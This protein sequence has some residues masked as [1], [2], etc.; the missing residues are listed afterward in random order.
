MSKLKRVAVWGQEADVNHV[1]DVI[2]G[3][4]LCATLKLTPGK[5]LDH[6]TD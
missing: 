5:A 2:V 4:G 1:R 3:G 6:F